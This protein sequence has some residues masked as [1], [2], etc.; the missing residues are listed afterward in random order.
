MFRFT[1]L[2]ESLNSE[3]VVRFAKEDMRHQNYESPHLSF[4]ESWK[5]YDVYIAHN[6]F[7]VRV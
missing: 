6:P 4:G 5:K 2:E 1:K 3:E 7:M